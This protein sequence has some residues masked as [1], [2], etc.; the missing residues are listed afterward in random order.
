MEKTPIPTTTS[1][2]DLGA[3]RSADGTYAMH[4]DYAV[5]K[6]QNIDS[7]IMKNLTVSSYSIGWTILKYMYN[8]FFYMP[9]LPGILPTEE[10]LLEKVQRRYS[11]EKT[12]GPGQI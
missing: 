6:A 1:F 9:Q 12:M 7:A 5:L 2:K 10:Q 11:K 8:L 4:G 3:V